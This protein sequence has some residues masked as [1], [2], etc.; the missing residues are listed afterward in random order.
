LDSGLNSIKIDA[1]FLDLLKLLNKHNA[2][3][4]II[5][6]YAFG[7]HARPRTTKD[8]DVFIGRDAQNAS[9]VMAAV[10]E[11]GFGE[12]GLSVADLTA[13]NSVIQLGYPP[14]RV[15]LITEI[16]GIDFDTAWPNRITADFGGEVVNVISRE[17]LI[18]SKLAA[19]RLRDLAD[20]E[21]LTARSSSPI[22]PARQKKSKKQ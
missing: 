12:T 9:R 20:V 22:K 14:V 15:D 11:F 17:D 8:I 6:G 2:R 18:T 16:K 4:L 19:G 21:E 13:E 1:D 5:G 7:V 10:D 3:Y